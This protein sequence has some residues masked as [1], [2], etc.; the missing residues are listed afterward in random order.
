MSIEKW[1][2]IEKLRSVLFYDLDFKIVKVDVLN[3]V[4]PGKAG[5]AETFKVG[6]VLIKPDRLR[7]VKLIAG[8]L[9]RS[10]NFVGTCV[11]AVVGNAGILEHMIILKNPCPK[12]KHVFLTF[13]R[14]TGSY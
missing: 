5:F 4:I 3:E 13:R 14:L 6:N 10:K 1:K 9:Q 2:V 12:P 8:L 7:K 11:R